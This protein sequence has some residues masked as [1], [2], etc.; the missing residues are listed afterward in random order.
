ME[1]GK[2][3]TDSIDHDGLFKEMLHQCFEL[4]LRLF[5]PQ[6]ASQL[7]FSEFTFLEQERLTDYPSGEH[8]YVDTLVEMR[9]LDGKRIWIH[10]ESQSSRKSGFPLRMFRYFSQ[11]RLRENVLIW[12]IVLYMPGG[13]D[14]SGFESYTEALFGETFLTFRYWCISLGDLEVEKYLATE[15]PVAYGLAPLMKRGDISNPRLKARYLKGIAMSNITQVQAALLAHFVETYLP[16][17]QAEQEEFEQLI[18]REEVN[19]MQFITSWERKG[20]AEE[21]LQSRREVLLYQLNEKFGTLSPTIS[22]QVQTIASVE[23]LDRL[24]RK[25]IHANSF[26]EIGLDGAR[27]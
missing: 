20:R 12:Q 2:N 8:R 1:N 4:F 13:G 3:D 26:A 24:L 15:N 21:A 19:V 5:Y 27:G 6:Q 7:D 16:L 22:Q 14:G 10:I 9:T 17:T 18:Q 23:E 11:L 25:L